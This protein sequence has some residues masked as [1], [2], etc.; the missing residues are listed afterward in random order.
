M[1]TTTVEPTV[2]CT[3]RL[4]GGVNIAFGLQIK[5]YI[6]YTDFT[7]DPQTSLIVAQEDRFDLP[8]WDILLR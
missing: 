8:G 6:V 1:N 7:I 2:T 4:S 3:W 5:P